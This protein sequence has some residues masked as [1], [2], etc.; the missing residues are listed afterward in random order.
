MKKRWQYFYNRYVRRLS[1]RWVL[2]CMVIILPINALAVVYSSALYGNYL[3]KTRSNHVQQAMGFADD[4]SRE[5]E[6]VTQALSY[7]FSSDSFGRIL[8][9]PSQDSSLLAVNFKNVISGIQDGNGTGFSYAWD[10]KNDIIYIFQNNAQYGRDAQEQFEEWIRARVFHTPFSQAKDACVLERHVFLGITHHFQRFSIGVYIDAGKKLENYYEFALEPK[11]TLGILDGNNVQIAALTDGN[12]DLSNGLSLS[13]ND[14]FLIRQPLQFGDYVFFEQ[15]SKNKEMLDV[16]R[17]P[18]LFWAL[19]AM[20][21]VGFA[22]MPMIYRLSNR[23]LIC[24]VARLLDAMEDLGQGN[25]KKRLPEAASTVDVEFMN[26]GFNRMAE[27]IQSLRIKTYEQEIEKLKTEAINLKLQVNPHMYLNALNTIYS[28]GRVGK[29]KELCEFTVLLMQYFR[30]SFRSDAEFG[31]VK[32]EMAFVSSY[33]KI[34]GMRFPGRFSYAFG[35]EPAAESIKIPRFIIENFAENAVKYA[36]QSEKETE[37]IIQTRLQEH[38]LFVS[39][40][41]DGCGMDETTL[42]QIRSGHVVEDSAGRH[43]GIWNS[44]RRLDFYYGNRYELSITSALGKGTQV[45][46]RIPAEINRPE[47]YDSEKDD[48]EESGKMQ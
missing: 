25:L 15:L 23:L 4:L 24:P 35:V 34:Q 17:L 22:A 26:K 16:G 29:T 1:F 5:M 19:V 43:T 20:T 7:Y 10:H 3:E 2:V 30:Y 11:G 46:L 31:T 44:R 12:W 27:E 9:N 45:Y 13:E 37:I 47:G 18:V 38:D 33:M 28:L 40:V 8:S 48:D 36:L 14:G 21:L 42:S 41:D 39:I 32:D 6:R